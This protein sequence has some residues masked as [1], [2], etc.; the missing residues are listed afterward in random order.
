MGKQHQPHEQRVIEERYE[1][2]A[3]L[4]K[5]NEF[6]KTDIFNGLPSQQRLLM[7]AQSS[8]MANYANI[9]ASRIDLF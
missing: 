5:L 9:L 8:A 2:E 4:E 1:L 3:K 6:M 7:S